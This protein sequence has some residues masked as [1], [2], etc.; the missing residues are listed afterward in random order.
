MARRYLL[1]EFDDEASANT[2]RARID[3]ATKRGKKYRVVGLFAKP[4]PDFCRCGEEL[5]YDVHT[6]ERGRKYIESRVGKRLGWRVCLECRKPL[7]QANFL[8]NLVKPNEIIDP[9]THEA[10]YK[11]R[12]NTLMFYFLGIS[13]P[14][15]V[16]PKK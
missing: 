3:E 11:G 8:R 12:V 15:R 13:A 9:D 4:G 14:T 6:F 2:L 10:K 16:V 1:I 7:P 5:P